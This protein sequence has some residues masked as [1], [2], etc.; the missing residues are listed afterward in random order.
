VPA[1]KSATSAR[2]RAAATELEILKLKGEIEAY[3]AEFKVLKNQDISIRTLEEQL[4]DLEESM[5]RKVAEQLEVLKGELEV[6]SARKIEEVL[7][8]E[9]A[10]EQRLITAQQCIMEAERNADRLQSKVFEITKL[11]EERA[12]A[13]AAELQI[14]AESNEKHQAAVGILER[15][16]ECLRGR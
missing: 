11:A 10:L 9:A 13:T 1:L 5:E 4:E 8:R 16:N 15:E 3:E 14:L 12:A 2:P 6:E 7:E